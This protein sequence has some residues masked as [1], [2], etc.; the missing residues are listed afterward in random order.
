M[1]ARAE[2]LANDRLRILARLS[3]LWGILILVRLL[4]L[5]IYRHDDLRRLAQQQQDRQVEIQAPR[6]AVFDRNHQHLALSLPV[7]SV[8]I[9]PLRIADVP[10]AAELLAK[11]LDLDANE[12]LGRIAAAVQDHR[13]FL[14]VKRKITPEESERLRSY[15]LEWVEFRTESRRFYPNGQLAAHVLGGVNH[16]EKGNAGIEL[17][18]DKELQGRSGVMRTTSDVKQRVIDLQVFS[19]PQPGKNLTLSIDERIQYIAERELKK[20][21]IE[22]SCKTGS[23]VAMNPKTGEIYAM[24][25]YPTYDPNKPPLPGEDVS[26]RV[27]LTV[28]SPFEPGSVFKVVTLSAGLETTRIRPDTM[29]NCGSGRM[30]LFKR[31]IHDAHPYSI[32]SMAD[33]LAKS[34]NIGAIQV[35]LKV[36]EENLYEYVRRFGF[37][38]LTGIPLPGE[39]AGML[40]KLDK[41]IPSSIG[42]IAMG[43]ELSTTTL[44]LAQACSVVANGGMLVKPRLTLQRQRPGSDP[45]AVENIP[46]PV[47]VLKPETAITMR[48]MMEGVVL[49]GTGKKA[50]LEGYTSGGKTGSAQIYDYHAR[51]YTHKYNASFMGFAPINNPAIVIVVTLNGASK[52][53]GAVAAPV[54]HDV[55]MAALRFLDVQKD[56]PEGE[57]PIDDGKT[58]LDDLAIAELSGPNPPAADTESA[59]LALAGLTSTQGD[60]S[61]QA[62]GVPAPDPSAPPVP[63]GPKV[64]NFQG[65]TLRSVL[66]ESS[67]L[68]VRVEFVG[69]GIARAQEPPP[70]A[71]LTAGQPVK[72]QF[73]R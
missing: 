5:Q 37:G 15:N 1:D 30:T 31:V 25:A 17:S 26:K 10:L 68:G 18:L 71:L 62:A 34:S 29:I 49:K 47:R 63:T 46:A 44:Q 14:W 67:A 42:S 65:K 64:P 36:G 59:P 4:W 22:N 45:D 35:G 33:V 66:E 27:N 55:A 16:E 70:G 56:L 6:G 43:H 32:L 69:T 40:R 60:L 52:F 12:L 3:L 54:F 13:G 24:A 48:H 61:G 2:L 39:S 20:A 21:V 50:Q 7:D 23:V 72:V 28:S 9:N 73:A 57:K 41:W 11:I 38:R 51:A 53:G 19:D 58:P 8:C